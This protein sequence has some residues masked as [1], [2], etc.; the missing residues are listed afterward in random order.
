MNAIL[1]PYV[2]M[3]ERVRRRCALGLRFRDMATNEWV[4]TGLRVRAYPVGRVA[5]PKD[6]RKIYATANASGVWVFYDLPD[7]RAFEMGAEENLPLRG[8]PPAPPQFQV[9]VEDEEKRFLPCTF[10]AEAVSPGPNSNV[11]P[12]FSA[13]ERTAP[14][15]C[16][17]IRLSLR[18]A[19][20]QLPRPPARGALLRV[21][22]GGANLSVLASG[23]A[24]K[25][26]EAVVM[27]PWP[28]PAAAAAPAPPPSWA[29]TV[30][31]WSHPPAP[32]FDLPHLDR[33]MERAAG[34]PDVLTTD[35]GA[36]AGTTL[37]YGRELIL[38]DDEP[39]F[40]TLTP[41]P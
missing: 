12:L 27:V 33:L 17:V 1:P 36:F 4:R 39:R 40:L 28:V 18:L 13:P 32:G 6:V 20:P 15:G 37:P 26:G 34:N 14:P 41:A 29:L 3:R 16:A 21:Q 10:V 11:C 9:E 22:L 30:R 25:D 19:S 24:N 7:T 8:N 5:P 35:S 38:P 31:A 23:L 2:E